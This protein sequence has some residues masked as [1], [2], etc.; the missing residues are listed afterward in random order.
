MSVRNRPKRSLKKALHEPTNKKSTTKKAEVT[1]EQL[2][3]ETEEALNEEQTM[4]GELKKPDLLYNLV[5]EIQKQGVKGEEDNILV[6]IMKIMLRLVCDATAE[7]SNMVVSDKSGSGK[8]W[9]TKKV[10]T[11]LIPEEKYHH[12]TDVTEK[13]T[14]EIEKLKKEL[15]RQKKRMEYIIDKSKRHW[16]DQ[17]ENENNLPVK[18]TDKK[19]VKKE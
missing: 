2:K 8:D 5:L 10:C 6:L 16:V 3:K 19:G 11:Y 1:K 4:I 18:H 7:S 17:E 14:S 9:I 12:I 15:E 13:Q